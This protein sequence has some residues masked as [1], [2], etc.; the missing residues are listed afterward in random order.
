MQPIASMPSSMI[1][2]LPSRSRT[3][4]SAPRSVL[5]FLALTAIAM[6][7]AF[8]R[9]AMAFSTGP[10]D[11]LAGEPPN[12]QTCVVCHGDFPLNSGDG[13]LELLDVPTNLTPGETY[14]LMVR[15]DD[16]GQSR[17]GFELT[18]LND[19]DEASGTLVVTDPASTQLSD[20]PAPAPDYLK[21]TSAGTAP[22]TSGPRAWVFDWTAGAD[23]EVTFY[24]AGNAANN[25]GDPFGDYIYAIQASAGGATSVV[26]GR[27]PAL[28]S[29]V[30]LD[31]NHPNPFNPATSIGFS[32]ESGAQVSLRIL[33]AGGRIVRELLDGRQAAGVYSVT[34][35]G[36][37][38]AGQ[39]VASGVYFYR[40]IAGEQ[41]S[42]R[43]MTLLQ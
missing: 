42:T 3:V 5:A 9:D 39:R 32:L 29:G 15:L 1:P 8:S 14:S 36:R 13:M 37:D 34:W 40:L 38:D 12:N 17:W 33:D 30:R 27:G 20:N 19:Q 2:S 21:H 22:G 25:S 28:R 31:Q 43:K 10:P 24:V 23:T 11:G 16:P 41:A 26:S 4:P 7:P 18:V 6:T 35:D